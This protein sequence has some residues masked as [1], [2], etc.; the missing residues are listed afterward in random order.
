MVW[1]RWELNGT[2]GRYGAARELL[3]F[4]CWWLLEHNRSGLAGA[5]AG[6]SREQ[7]EHA[8]A[9]RNH[10]LA[11]TFWAMGPSA[12]PVSLGRGIGPDGRIGVRSTGLCVSC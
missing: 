1:S 8:R 5:R 11:A 4:T 10:S 12:V 2:T 7:G 6:R 3:P 9:G